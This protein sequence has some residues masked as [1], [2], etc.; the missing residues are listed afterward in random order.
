MQSP[1]Y[2][3]SLTVTT[4]KVVIEG[5][6][7][8]IGYKVKN[9]GTTV[10]PGGHLTVEI[11]WASL[12]QR[13]YQS[14]V[15]NNPLSPDSEIEE[16]NYSQAPLMAGYTW[17]NVIEAAAS[18]GNTVEVYNAGRAR[19]WPYRQ[20]GPGTFIKQPVFAVRA[21]TKEEIYSQWALWVAAG[22]L[23][24]VAAFQI[25]DWIL[26]YYLKMG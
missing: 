18:N 5:V 6:N 24:V 3:L 10:F 20:I 19:V 9:I 11:S 17:F 21:R 15:I 25:A 2:Q 1:P 8:K 14:I 13:V 23:A 22:S 16:N 4:P 7:F 26:K 12:D